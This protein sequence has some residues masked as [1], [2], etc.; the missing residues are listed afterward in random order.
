MTRPFEGRHGFWKVARIDIQQR[1]AREVAGENR[2][3]TKDPDCPEILPGFGETLQSEYSTLWEYGINPKAAERWQISLLNGK[4]PEVDQQNKKRQFKSM[5][6][7]VEAI[8]P[9]F[10]SVKAKNL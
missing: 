10:P 4:I 3:T 5:E 6:E 9:L 7:F 8:S 1:V 2:P